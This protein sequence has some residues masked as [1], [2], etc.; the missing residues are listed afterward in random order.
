MSFPGEIIM[1]I[2]IT[3]WQLLESVRDVARVQV[4][5]L[6]PMS[7]R[8]ARAPISTEVTVQLV[9]AV[10]GEWESQ[11]SF[12][13]P[14]GQSNGI[15]FE[16]EDAPIPTPGDILLLCP[17][18]GARNLGAPI[19]YLSTRPDRWTERDWSGLAPLLRRSR[20]AEA[21]KRAPAGQV[22]SELAQ[23]S[24]ADL[25]LSPRDPKWGGTYPTDALLEVWDNTSDLGGEEAA[26]AVQRAIDTWN[27]TGASNFSIRH[28]KRTG[29]VAASGTD[30]RMILRW[31]PGAQPGTWA[32]TS[33]TFDLATGQFIDVDI[34]F[35]DGQAFSTAPL[36][37]TGDIESIALHELGH[38]AGAVHSSNPADVMYRGIAFGATK[39]VLMPGDIA[40]LQALYGARLME[41][42]LFY[43]WFGHNDHFYTQVPYGELAPDLGYAFEG[44][45]FRLFPEGTAQTTR[46]YRW[47]KL[48]GQPV[49][50]HFYTTDPEG[51]TAPQ[52]GYAYEGGVGNIATS[53]VPNSQPLYR[54]FNPTTGDHLYTLTPLEED[55]V[56]KGYR[57][58]GLAGYVL[59]T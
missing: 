49:G 22:D 30:R 19:T 44:A 1:L 39:R 42:L 2:D 59:P 58:E 55:P 28:V 43:R 52:D 35:W 24:I 8:R 46:W 27:W 26:A 38:F 48:S 7:G 40:Q 36:P 41:P 16:V 51:E 34:Q 13:M 12:L 14:G 15:A 29:G 50:D 56:S 20:G 10:A 23:V 57:G 6:R 4:L 53:Q 11:F 5:S 18:G 21:S 17:S 32:T 9:Q 45:A 25:C 3:L 37:N 54:F 31:T 33:W 47:V